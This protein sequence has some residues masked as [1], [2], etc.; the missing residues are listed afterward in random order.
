MENDKQKQL[1]R[2]KLLA[3]SLLLAATLTFIV[4]LFL[5]PNFWVNGVKA[6]AEAAMVGALADWFAVVA[7][8]RRVPIPFISRHTAIIP[9][10]KDRIGDNLGRFV[11]EKFL[12]SE[13][14]L[15]LIRRHD[16]AQMLADWLAQG[17][18]AR[19][20]SH[21]LLQVMRGFLDLTDDSRI[22]DFLRRAVHRALDKVDFSQS[23]ALIL[24]SMTRNNR[25][26]ALLDAT[27]D[28]LL[29]LLNRP[30]TRAFIARQI[31]SWL[32]REHPIKA[33]MLPTE[34][35]GEQSAEVVANAVDSI[36]DEVAIDQG[37]ELR[38]G[39]NR[40]VAKLIERL[41]SDQ[42]MAERA[43]M[44]KSWLKEDATL[45][46]YIGELWQDLRSW[47]RQDLSSDNSRVE[48]RMQQ[49]AQWLGETLLADQALRSAMNQHLEEAA[50]SAAPDF[51]AFLTRHISDTVKSWDAR[52]MSR[53]IELN[54]GRDLQ[55]IRVNGTLVGGS[56]GLI[57]YLLSQLPQVL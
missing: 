30:D 17:E 46:Q 31:T 38:Q 49:A 41:K 48:Q 12:D 10:N 50:R 35:L 56:I 13:S 33:K 3:L 53:Q 39:F 11:Q 4:T 15:S 57:L 21:H 26:Q 22:Q 29:S 45:N 47:L 27:I 55:F 28:Q 23:A 9:R 20:V 24:E 51:S 36:L 8:F 5:P 19:R 1:Q 18:N 40:A 14:L 52:D 34:W 43:E 2:S 44:V 25:H 37:H 42:E 16:P 7:L 54:I 32:K 6:V